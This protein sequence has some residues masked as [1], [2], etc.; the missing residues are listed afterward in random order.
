V[1][2]VVASITVNAPASVALTLVNDPTVAQ[3]IVANSTSAGSISVSYLGNGSYSAT[4]GGNIAYLTN[5]G[6]SLT[7]A[8]MVATGDTT[9][10][11]GNTT[12]A[13]GVTG[14]PK[15]YS[16]T[17]AGYFVVVTGGA[18][19]IGTGLTAGSI[20]LHLYVFQKI[21]A[22]ESHVIGSY[23]IT[24]TYSASASF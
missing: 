5:G 24:L 11:L 18:Q 8:L 2:F 10:Q 14:T 13:A 20:T 22:D 23:T 1:S 4:V 17:D 15:A 12:N 3:E 9:A 19:S 16:D 7:N 6:E 21:N